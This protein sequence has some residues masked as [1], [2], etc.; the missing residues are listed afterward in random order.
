MVPAFVAAAVVII[1]IVWIF[2]PYKGGGWRSKAELW[3]T[4]ERS[5]GYP[6]YFK[7]QYGEKCGALS[8]CEGCVSEGWVERHPEAYNRRPKTI[9]RSENIIYVE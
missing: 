5:H 6:L 2:N 7:M 1:A 9:T 8:G 4:N 3:K